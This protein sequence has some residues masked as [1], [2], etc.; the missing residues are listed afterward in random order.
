MNIQKYNKA[1]SNLSFIA[2]MGFAVAVLFAV[3]AY[4]LTMANDLSPF[5]AVAVPIIVA[6]SLTVSFVA[7][8]LK[9]YGLRLMKTYR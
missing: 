6:V 1:Q 8:A 7:V 5:G 3:D 4:N 9:L 2:G